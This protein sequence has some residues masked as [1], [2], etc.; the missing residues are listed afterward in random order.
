MHILKD[1]PG[2]WEI[3][4]VPAKSLQRSLRILQ[5]LCRLLKIL[6]E[7][8]EGTYQEPYGSSQGPAKI[9]KSAKILKNL[10]RDLKDLN[11]ALARSFRVLVESLKGPDGSLQG[12]AKILQV[13]EF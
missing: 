2:S 7:D 12:P 1:L 4:Q 9:L 11:W 3:L 5:D 10:C 6:A 8:P 13:L